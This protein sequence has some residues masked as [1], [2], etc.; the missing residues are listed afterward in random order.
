MR[1]TYIMISMK[2][3]KMRTFQLSKIIDR[4]SIQTF[5]TRGSEIQCLTISGTSLSSSSL[6]LC[7]KMRVEENAPS[8]SK[9]L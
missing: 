6:W 5:K 7:H 8:R 9:I 1:D 3:I 2:I 4:E